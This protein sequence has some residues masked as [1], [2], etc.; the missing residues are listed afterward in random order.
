MVRDLTVDMQPFYEEWARVKPYVDPVEELDEP[1]RIRPDSPERKLID[2]ALDCISCG[3]C[4]SSCGIADH[5][6]VGVYDGYVSKACVHLIPSN[7][8]RRSCRIARAGS[9]PFGQTALQP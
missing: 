4:Y 5:R 8:Q 6:D 3:A 9:K 7:R 1:A 2:P